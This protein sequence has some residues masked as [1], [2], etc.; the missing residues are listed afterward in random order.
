VSLEIFGNAVPLDRVM[1]KGFKNKPIEQIKSELFFQFINSIL[2]TTLKFEDL[3]INASV[4]GGNEFDGLLQSVHKDN[5]I[6]DGLLNVSRTS[7]GEN[8][9]QFI[10][11]VDEAVNAVAG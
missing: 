10:D 9:D 5:T 2:S 4:A 6:D 11:L 3:V 8:D 1:I 7:K